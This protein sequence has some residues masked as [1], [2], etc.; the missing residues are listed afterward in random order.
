MNFGKLGPTKSLR[1]ADSIGGFGLRLQTE[2]FYQGSRGS[3]N[4]ETPDLKGADRINRSRGFRHKSKK[5]KRL[6]LSMVR[7][8]NRRAALALQNSQQIHK[9]NHLL[10]S[11]LVKITHRYE[12]YKY[13][14]MQSGKS[15]ST[16]D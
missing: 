3:S 13:L 12:E 1:S 4:S 8:I 15:I 9:P 5:H 2:S 10:K 14:H 6:Q 7:P 16:S 11:K